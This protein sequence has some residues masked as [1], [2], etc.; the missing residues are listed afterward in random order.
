MAETYE[1]FRLSLIKSPQTNLFN[2]EVTRED[3]IKDIFSR[4]W[5]FLHYKTP[6]HYAPAARSDLAGTESLLGYMGKSVLTSEN[7]PPEEGLMESLHEGWRACV[8]AVDPSDEGDGQ[9]LA[10]ELDLAVGTPRSILKSFFRTVNASYGESPYRV[11]PQPIFD[12]ASFWSFADQY[13]G[14]IVRLTFDF[15]VPNGL[16]SART[17]LHSELK[18]A[19][20]TMKAQ[21]VST[22]LKSHAGLNT[23]AAPVKE[24]VEYAERGS[25]TIKAKTRSGKRFT[26]ETKAKRVT[27]TQDISSKVRSRLARAARNIAKL[28]DNE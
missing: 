7:L 9:K 10:I 13:R 20:E 24:A 11:E 22:T 17:N 23:D 18:E 4:E 8:I 12:A 25:G 5:K 2:R 1:L 16:W 27:L 21:E 19:H 15:V 14:D 3:H 26:S 6:F 28:L